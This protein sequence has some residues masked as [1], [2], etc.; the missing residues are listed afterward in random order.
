[1]RARYEVCS[2]QRLI[3]GLT[4]RATQ[5]YCPQASGVGTICWAVAGRA[6]DGPA[7]R[8]GAR[9]AAAG[10]DADDSHTSAAGGGGDGAGGSPAAARGGVAGGPS[11]RTRRRAPAHPFVVDRVWAPGAVPHPVR[12]SAP[13]AG[14]SGGGRGRKRGRFAR[15]WRGQGTSG[16]CVDG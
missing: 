8:N 16:V 3:D 5:P 2:D 4:G 13:R 6:V 1:M 15:E 12:M 10:R 11:V 14:R 7:A 9:D